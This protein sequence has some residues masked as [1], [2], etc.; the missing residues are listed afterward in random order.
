M[1]RCGVHVSKKA[2]LLSNAGS[3]EPSLLVLDVTSEDAAVRQER[4]RRRTKQG[5]LGVGPAGNASEAV[6]QTRAPSP[7][8]LTPSPR[9]TFPTA[10]AAACPTS[11]MIG[12]AAAGAQ[13]AAPE[14]RHRPRGLRQ[15]QGS[16]CPGVR[17]RPPHPPLRPNRH[18]K[19]CPERAAGTPSPR[20]GASSPGRPLGTT[21]PT[22]RFSQPP[23]APR[24]SPLNDGRLPQ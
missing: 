18:P 12:A 11:G 24:A 9:H 4:L 7:T 8:P 16:G 10:G 21:H 14:R 17:T 3:R 23:P 5:L 20:A 19:N 22:E 6:S 2:T 13:V 1:S 15:W